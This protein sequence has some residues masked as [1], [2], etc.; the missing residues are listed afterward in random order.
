MSFDTSNSRVGIGT[1]AP[2]EELEVAG[3]VGAQRFVDT[4]SATYYLDPAATDTSLIVD[5]NIISNGAFS[6]T[7]NGT[8]GNITINAGSGTVV[9]GATGTGKLDA[10]TI[11]PPYTINGDKFAT[12]L[13][14]MTGVKEETTGT[15]NTSEHIP[16]YGYRT[17]LDLA[18]APQG[19][20]LWLF[21]EVT[22]LH[23][24]MDQLVILLSASANTRVWYRLQ[25]DSGQVE[26]YSEEPTKVSYRLTA[27]RFDADSWANTRNSEDAL[28]FV[29]EGQTNWNSNLPLVSPEQDSF[30]ISKLASS[31]YQLVNSATG[32]IVESTL[33][34]SRGLIANLQAGTIETQELISPLITATNI[35]T[36]TLTTNNL[37][38]QTLQSDLIVSGNIDTA[39]ISARIAKLEELDVETLRAG[40]IIADS[41]TANSIE[42]LD[43]KIASLSAGST[44]ELSDDDL[45]TITDR[46]KARLANLTGNTE[47]AA[48]LPTPPEATSQPPEADPSW[49]YTP[50]ASDSATLASLDADMVF[51]NDYLAV[52]GQATITNL[53]VTGYFY[54][55]SLTAKSGTLSLQPGG[56]LIRMANDTLI[57][58]SSGQVM[59]NGDLTVSG[60]ILAEKAQLGSLE[61]GTPP[62]TPSSSLGKLLAVYNESG[63]AVATIDASGSASF[64]DLSTRLIT[65]A[66]PSDASESASTSALAQALGISSKSNATAGEAT[67]V[68]PNTEIVIESK[69]VTTDSLVYLTPVSNTDNKVLFVKAKETCPPP[70]TGVSTVLKPCTR[71]F[72]VAIDSP[73]STDISFNWWIIKLEAQ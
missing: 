71:S 6:L 50:I 43:A 59:V 20:D 65:I 68:S 29:L 63:E 64:R 56:G 62:A 7:S 49:E 52:I 35:T 22:N 16:G 8:N 19:S 5:G 1:A 25:A 66:A 41:I 34:A 23:E 9:I 45:E 54:S 12:Y 44:G 13:S 47:T 32:Q 72:T 67:L 36:S 3:D 33:T 28:G 39:S 55:D 26:I 10:G 38:T 17:V 30:S 42:G 15:V 58:D 37:S 2:G 21:R 57:V 73:A 31:F 51:V 14:G 4:A 48:D 24:Q 40:N 53:D 27:P 61:L 69:Y 18:S 46:I 11:D 60:K 70:P